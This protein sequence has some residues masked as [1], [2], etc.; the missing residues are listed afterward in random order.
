MSFQPDDSI[1]DAFALMDEDADA[2]VIPGDYCR[3]VRTGTPG[4]RHRIAIN[5]TTAHITIQ[6]QSPNPQR[7]VESYEQLKAAM[8]AAATDG[9]QPEL[10]REIAMVV[11]EHEGRELRVC[12][13]G[14]ASDIRRAR[15]RFRRGLS[16]L[17]PLPLLGAITQPLA[18]SATAV[19]IA[20]APVLPPVHQ[21]D[22]PPAPIVR[23][24]TG[25]IARPELPYAPG[26]VAP[27]L[28]A[29]QWT[30]R[31]PAPTAPPPE[32]AAKDTTPTQPRRPLVSPA[33]VVTPP[34][35]A[36]TAPSPAPTPTPTRE[37]ATAPTED[38]TKAPTGLPTIEV[39]DAPESPSEPS[40]APTATVTE[41]LERLLQPARGHDQPHN[42]HGRHHL[43][44]I[45]RHH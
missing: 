29:L 11:W 32:A 34:P 2:V 39:T 15:S 12:A 10:P 1:L 18:G 40:P 23:E 42:R 35:A 45:S 6:A 30:V 33:P 21:P 4:S 17:S 38:P 16:A 28:G 36:R 9:I 20:M 27:R 3:A 8:K 22:I 26:S 7:D 44:R 24:M 25:D 14:T 19:G 31:T 13:P 43:R 5:K 41:L 37:E